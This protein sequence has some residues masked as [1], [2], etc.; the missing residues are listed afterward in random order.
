VVLA[1]SYRLTAGAAPKI[2]YPELAREVDASSTERATLAET[3]SS[4]TCSAVSAVD[5]G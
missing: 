4:F 3:K 5:G 2:A 1:A